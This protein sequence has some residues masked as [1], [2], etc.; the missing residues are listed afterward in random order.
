MGQPR[1]HPKG[2][3]TQRLQN[4]W[5]PFIPTPKQF[6][7]EQPNLVCE[8]K[9]GSSVFLGVSHASSPGAGPQRSPKFMDLLHARAQYEKQQPKFAR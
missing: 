5:D 9:W 7:I 3:G 4:V 2:A 8:R 1:P 6:D